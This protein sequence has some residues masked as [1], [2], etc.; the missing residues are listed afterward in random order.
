MAYQ[1]CRIAIS[2]SAIGRLGFK[3]IV[4]APQSLAGRR[5]V[6]HLSRY[7]FYSDTCD[8]P[9]EQRLRLPEASRNRGFPSL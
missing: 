4:Q 7:P 3:R 1:A 2:A 8:F 5:D 6:Q 9:T